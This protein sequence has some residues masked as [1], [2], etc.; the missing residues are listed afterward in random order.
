MAVMVPHTL[1]QKMM[2]NNYTAH[3][4]LLFE[5]GTMAVMVPDTLSQKMMC[6]NYTAHTTLLL[7]PGTMAGD[8]APHPV[9]EDNV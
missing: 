1:S 7:E 2:C 6:N 3:T 8:G 5:P 9:T 4:T